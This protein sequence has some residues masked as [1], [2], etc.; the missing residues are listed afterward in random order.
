MELQDCKCGRKPCVKRSK[1]IRFGKSFLNE[2]EDFTRIYCMK[3]KDKAVVSF[4]GYDA[5][6]KAWNEGR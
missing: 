4:I 1:Q 3:C 2:T 5:A 6:V